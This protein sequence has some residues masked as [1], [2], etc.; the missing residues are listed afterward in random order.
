MSPITSSYKRRMGRRHLFRNYIL[1]GHD[2]MFTFNVKFIH[3]S[4]PYV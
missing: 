3:T 2:I 1:A 4:S